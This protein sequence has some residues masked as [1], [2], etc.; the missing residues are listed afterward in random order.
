[1]KTFIAF[2]LT[3]VLA[4]FSLNAHAQWVHTNGPGIT[5]VTCVAVHADDLY[6]GT[7]ASGMFHSSDNGD[8]WTAINN[9]LPDYSRMLAAF[10]DGPDL[11]ASTQDSVYYSTDKGLHWTNTHLHASTFFAKIQNR[12]FAGGYYSDDHGAHWLTWTGPQ[13]AATDMMALGSILFLSTDGR[14]VFFSTDDGITWTACNNGLTDPRVHALA[15]MGDTLLAGTEYV[16]AFRSIDSGKTWKTSN[17][18]LMGLPVYRFAST[19]RNIFAAAARFFLSTDFGQ[20]WTPVY[21]G[22]DGSPSDI[23][24]MNSEYLYTAGFGT[25]VWRRS[26]ADFEKALVKNDQSETFSILPNPVTNFV[27]ISS[28]GHVTVS[29]I[30]GMIVLDV[31]NHDRSNLTLD[32]SKLPAGTYFVRSDGSSSLRKLIKE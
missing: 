19:C 27:T 24:G 25:F 30:L 17:T 4:S 10:A 6:A 2:S 1:M 5:P 12:L 13:A 31:T 29:N 22:L 3:L 32:V 28:A 21:T 9:G 20:I 16:G 26:L 18:G 7:Q 8:N 15:V 14:G 11:F 23:L